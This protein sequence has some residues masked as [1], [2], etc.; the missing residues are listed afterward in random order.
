M[1]N[2]TIEKPKYTAWSNIRFMLR[3]AWKHQKR[4]IVFMLLLTVINTALN[5]T[6]LFVA[7][8]ILQKVENSAP[9]HEL[10]ITTA[11]F[12]AL[13]FILKAAQE[14]CGGF[15]S[16]MG[17]VDLRMK[18]IKGLTFK[19]F[20]TAYPNTCSP[21]AQKKLSA[22]LNSTLNNDAATEHIW[23]TLTDLLTAVCGFIIYLLLLK[24]VS[25]IL[26]L[27]TTA[28]SAAGFF[29]ARWADNRN[30]RSRDKI[31]EFYDKTTY[32]QKQSRST[33]FAKDTRIFGLQHWLESIYSGVINAYRSFT[34]KRE[35]TTFFANLCNVLLTLLRNGAAYAYLIRMAVNNNLSTSEFLLYFAAISG[36]TAW[37]SGILGQ[38]AALH[39]ESLD[40]SVVREYL[41][42][43]EPFRFE[44]GKPVPKAEEYELR[45]EN[46][47]FRYPGSDKNI[48]ENLNLT[49]HAGE[50][51]A[52]VGLN[53]AGK[54]T[55]VLLLCGFYDPDEGRILLNGQDIREFNR[56][57]YYDLLSA[58]YQQY[59]VADVNI[60][61]N[62]AS[63][64]HDINSE[65]VWECLEKEGLSEFV[66]TLPKQLETPVGR[67]VYSDGIMFSGGQTQR[68]MLA[69]ALYKD[70]PILILDEPTA[71]LDP[72]AEN[73]IYMKYN[74]M[75]AGKTSLFIS[76][77][78]A[79]TRFCDRIIFIKDGVIAEEGTHES[80]LASGGEYAQLFKVQSRYYQE[81]SDFR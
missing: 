75:T 15:A 21:D 33:E 50:K 29:A 37:V 44:G 40:I 17:Q 60:A 19:S 1:T 41:D 18:I 7:P 80:L 35:K 2:K 25:P 64:T 76:H 52:V 61:Q 54:T 36:F 28:L 51:L 71:A 16:V 26:M 59:S 10:L 77:R 13:L 11:V 23:K 74:E 69:R 57:D 70:G 72:I 78:L 12:T 53:G 24:N 3:A 31:W 63:D 39:K 49:V 66:K 62:V 9:I 32:L 45:A 38:F 73:D 55:L 68:L 48:F 27:I 6:E 22:S 5:L 20:V 65:K 67:D 56:R 46:V 14:F 30:F 42:Y 47:T 4:V 43:P 34:L 58:V 79:F 8:G 81:G